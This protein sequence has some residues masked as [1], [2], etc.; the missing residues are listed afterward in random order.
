MRT[1]EEYIAQK[2]QQQKYATIVYVVMSIVST[3]SLLLS[4]SLVRSGNVQTAIYWILVAIFS[5][6]GKVNAQH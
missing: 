3:G 2:Q 4:L 1:V 5:H 6:I